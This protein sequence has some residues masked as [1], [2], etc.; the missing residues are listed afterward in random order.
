M[1]DRVSQKPPKPYLGTDELLENYDREQRGN[2]RSAQSGNGSLADSSLADMSD[3][4]R[5]SS[6]FRFGKSLASSFNPNN[7][8]I[9]SKQRQQTD[10]T[11]QKLL[12][13]RKEEAQRK[14]QELKKS[15]YFRN[16]AIGTK[17]PFADFSDEAGRGRK[18]DSAVEFSDSMPRGSFLRETSIQDKRKGR[19]FLENPSYQDDSP[20]SRFLAPAKR[21]SSSSSST[22]NHPFHMKRPSLFDLGYSRGVDFGRSMT[23][24]GGQSVRK[25]P[26]RKEMH[27]Q[28]KLVKRVSDLE[29]KLNAAR[30]QLA[31]VLGEPLPQQPPTIGRPRFIPGALASLPSERL[32]SGYVNDNEEEFEDDK[33]PGE[34][35]V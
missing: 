24:L 20:D 22:P 13:D 15:D 3:I 6:I 18:H 19:V 4:S 8:K 12:R 17:Q 33:I 1:N 29:S 14:F 23:N 35:Y 30:R 27:Q 28:Q 26:S 32:L 9:W 10:D 34:M 16:T 11:Q 25:I 31:D 5:S 7:W 21:P 2:R